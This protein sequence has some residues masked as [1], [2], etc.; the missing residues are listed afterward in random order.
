MVKRGKRKPNI[1]RRIKIL[2]LVIALVIVALSAWAIL[3]YQFFQQELTREIAVYGIVGLF[4]ISFILDF[5]P[6]IV[7]PY[8]L[9]VAA[10]SAGLN[11]HFSIILVVLGSAL[12]SML[13]LKVG[14]KYG[15]EF[16][17]TL[18]KEKTI[19]KILRFWERY[20]KIFVFFTAFTPLPYFPI[21]FGSLEMPKKDFIKFGLIPRVVGLLIFGYG[22]YFGMLN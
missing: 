7:N 4:F 6:Q 17:C 5:V 11:A 16:I 20:A 19:L 10:L 1:R 9:I 2:D 15:F 22:F 18:F 8:F 13:G 12:G 21:V 14:R 3:K